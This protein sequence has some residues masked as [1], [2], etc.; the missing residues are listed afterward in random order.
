[1][2]WNEIELKISRWKK[3]WKEKRNKKNKIKYNETKQ[4]W[5]DWMELSDIQMT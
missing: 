4:N 2:A 3:N 1:M 5:I